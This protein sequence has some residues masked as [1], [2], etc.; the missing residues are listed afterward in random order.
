[1]SAVESVHTDGGDLPPFDH[2]TVIERSLLL[3]L[4]RRLPG[5]TIEARDIAESSCLST[6]AIRI[7]GPRV[8][9][10]IRKSIELGARWLAIAAELTPKLKRKRKRG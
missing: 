3:A 6:Q 9:P 5:I 4:E 1:M 8:A 2:H 10:Q 7:R